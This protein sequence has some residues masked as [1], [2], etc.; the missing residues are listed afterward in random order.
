MHSLA[1]SKNWKYNINML[2]PS[3]AGLPAPTRIAPGQERRET[4]LSQCASGAGDPQCPLPAPQRAQLQQ[5]AHLAH[6][7]RTQLAHQQA[8]MM[9]PLQ[10]SGGGHSCPNGNHPGTEETPLSAINARPEA[11]DQRPEQRHAAVYGIPIAVS[12][13]GRE[14]HCK[15]CM[16]CQLALRALGPP[17]WVRLIA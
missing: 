12:G 11:R 3:H 4:C 13:V 6:Q 9:V 5:Q 2:R 15:P 8:Q 14:S 17:H 7:H 16:P 10:R 1:A